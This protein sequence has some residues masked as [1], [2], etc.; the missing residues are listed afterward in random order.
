MRRW[1]LLAAALAAGVATGT[2]AQIAP[3][4]PDGSPSAVVLHR[5]DWLLQEPFSVEELLRWIAGVGMA[6]SGALGSPEI[7]EMAGSTNGRVELVV[8]GVDVSE[9][10]Y[11]WPRLV[12]VQVG[13]IDSIEVVR[14][15][16]PARIAIWTRR[17]PGTAPVA[18]LDLARGELGTRT[19]R[20]QLFTPP[21]ALE[22]ALCYEEL[23]READDF[24]PGPEEVLAE[25]DLG[26][27]TGRTLLARIGL[28]RGDD[29]LRIEYLERLEESHG[30]V[31]AQL[32]RTRTEHTRTG[33]R[34]ERPLGAAHMFLD[35]GHQAWR[36]WTRVDA[37]DRDP[38]DARTHAAL[39][40][41]IPTLGG[42]N[43]WVRFRHAITTGD[44]TLP[45][46]RN[47]SF[48]QQRGEI[49]LSRPGSVRLDLW[50]GAA[51][52]ARL[53]TTWEARGR[54][55]LRRGP[56]E[57]GADCGRGVGYAGW[58]E[59]GVERVRTGR[60]GAVRARLQDASWHLEIEAFGKDLDGGSSASRL[61]VGA[62]Q[63]PTRIGGALVQLAWRRSR[64]P[65]EMHV[66]STY[67]W[68]PYLRGD[69]AGRPRVDARFDV[70]ASRRLR[71]D[72]LVVTVLTT[73]ML[74][75]DRPFPGSTIPRSALGDA[76]LD[77]QF[78]E[79]LSFFAGLRNIT[80]A[81]VATFPGAVLP[82]RLGWFGVRARL[83]D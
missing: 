1:A 9:P 23:L 52:D 51:R 55:T 81:D 7:V 72:D 56:F 41:A 28:R 16:D 71:G 62:G 68:T 34:W 13:M 46:A 64:G 66:S 67:G 75:D 50:G 45:E 58:D 63:G 79:R 12:P 44:A 5:S 54:A 59:S 2:R 39:D 70:R 65:W 40:I 14:T 3:L 37:V 17:V 21:R 47:A 42:W 48:T 74:D 19:R 15:T 35:L 43:P 78:L 49:Q 32:D 6:R 80:D 57:L 61:V 82:D 60:F 26:E 27:Y 20:A 30:S 83:L 25:A 73:W 69:A 36:R 18:D 38:S 8:D 29:A 24:R 31:A 10:D 4:V 11:S 53:G 76:T 77:L 33:L 22:V